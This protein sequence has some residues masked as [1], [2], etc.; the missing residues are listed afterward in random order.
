MDTRSDVR[1]APSRWSVAA[2]TILAAII[3]VHSQAV[4]AQ[5][6]AAQGKWTTLPSQMPINPVH[7]A[8]LHTG[9]VLWLPGSGNV[10][11]KRI[12]RPASGIPTPVPSSR[13]R[14]PGTCSAT[15]W[16]SCPM[17]GRSSM[18]APFNTI[19]FTASRATPSFDPADRHVHRCAEHGARTL[20]PDRDDAGRRPCDDILRAEGDRRDEYRSR[21]LHAGRRMEP[22]VPGRLDA[23]AVSTHASA[24]GRQ[25]ALFRVGHGIA[26]LQS[27][28]A[29]VDRGRRHDQ[30]H[31]HRTYGTSV[32]LPLRPANGYTARVMIFGGG[33]PAT[34][35]TEILDTVG[36]TAALA[37]RARRCRSRASR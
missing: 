25:R 24:S 34:A 30:L 23:A 1:L 8:L 10:A 37:V 22:G 27:V 18:A 29:R 21:D 2:A 6:P 15:A 17:A 13:S 5:Q 26:H 36:A 7:I 32:L 20:V 19:P 3:A 31:R 35:T 28:D 16:S 11:G 9:K 14:S 4:R 12:S 33:N